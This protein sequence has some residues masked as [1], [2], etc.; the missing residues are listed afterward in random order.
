MSD[1]LS[2]SPISLTPLILTG[3]ILLSYFVL[4]WFLKRVITSLG[5]LKNVPPARHAQVYKYFR[6]VLIILTAVMLLLAWGIDYR[7]L[8]VVASS[9]LAMLA[10]ALVAQWS[11][12]SNITA[13]VLIFFSFPV[14]IGDKMEIIDGASTVIGEIVEINL[15]QIILRDDDGKMVSY[16]NNLLLQKAVR[17]LQKD[18]V[19]P[20]AKPVRMKERLKSD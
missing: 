18:D 4:N 17:K 14:R 1:L 11:I 13:G 9:I 7:G 15:F 16:P 10:V 6:V 12:L 8:V 3:L 19:S 5:H 2:Y 20:G